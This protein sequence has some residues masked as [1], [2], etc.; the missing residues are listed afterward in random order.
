VLDFSSAAEQVSRRLA[1]AIPSTI[2]PA[3][4]GVSWVLGHHLELSRLPI[5]PLLAWQ[6][7]SV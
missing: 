6:W 3:A 4:A 2:S 7:A 5:F 1:L